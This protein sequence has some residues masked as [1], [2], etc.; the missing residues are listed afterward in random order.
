MLK[1]LFF[2]ILLSISLASVASCGG[3]NTPEPDPPITEEPG[4]PAIEN[5][6]MKVLQTEF[7]GAEPGTEIVIDVDTNI[8]EW[9]VD[10]E[11]VAWLEEKSRT[12]D[13]IVFEITGDVMPYQDRRA[14][15]RFSV[16]PVYEVK[17]QTVSVTYRKSLML[18][19]VFNGDGT[20]KNLA[21]TVTVTVSP[22]FGLMTYMNEAFGGNM[23][24]F[25]NTPGTAVSSGYYKADYSSSDSFKDGLADGHSM[26]CLF[27]F[28]A[29]NPGT[30]EIK[31]FSSHQSGGTGIMLGRGDKEI[32]FLPNVNA[33]YVW[34]R[35]GIVPERGRY[36]H[37]VGV[38][39]KS[40]GVSKIYVDGELK[41]SVPAHGN[42]TLPGVAYCWFCIG[43]DTASGM[44]EAAWRG[45][46]AIARVYD[47]VLTDERVSELWK[48]AD[49]GIPANNIKIDDVV[50]FEKCRLASGSDFPVLGRGFEAGDEIVWASVLN[51]GTEFVSEGRFASE[52]VVVRVP[53][54]LVSGKY[55]LYVK[56][57]D[58]K[59]PLGI[60]DIDVSGVQSE[61]R[62]PKII[63]HRCF[64]KDGRPENSMAAL[65]AAVELG[66]YGAEIDVWTTTDNVLVVNHDG[67]IG[68]KKIQNCTYD[69]VRDMTLGNG[70]KLPLFED[71]LDYIGTVEGTKL[72]IEFKDHAD[73]S[74]E[75]F[76][77]DEAI[78]MVTEKGLDEHVEY[79]AFDFELCKR[80][81]AAKP[82]AMVGYLSGNLQLSEVF[83]AGV[84]SIDYSFNT[85][86]LHPEW[87]VQARNLGMTVNVWT[88]NS[89]GDLM[90]SISSGV[91]YITTD[92]PDRLKVILDRL[93]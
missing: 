76:A 42:L 64:H 57:G 26:E 59:C 51:E 74:R 68:G 73:K 40:N 2:S 28:D 65:K 67:V 24:H 22:G 45:D 63:A 33:S 27:M 44:A 30:S 61:L 41:M 84:H 58:R 87:I 14:K 20:A 50:F 21:E 15:L 93:F 46:V 3:M 16:N 34:T 91:D 32:T 36:Y 49:Y 66:V 82:D 56:R 29:E 72:I 31:M 80:I 90:T 12:A 54:G 25:G 88:V 17:A 4:L 92:N 48:R 86:Q 89:D 38:W 62:H 37:V 81:A 70:E 11:D 1:S 85:L 79:I 60:T 53:D 19:V 9:S 52:S 47:E 6:Y 18:D 23:A 71:M 5:P 8:P 77:V 13:R 39:D 10:V 83:A 78:R 75:E 7:A 69:E 55:K 35:S 43:G